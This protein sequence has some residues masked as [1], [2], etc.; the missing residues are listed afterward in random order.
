MPE[1]YNPKQYIAILRTWPQVGPAETD[2]HIVTK[3]FQADQT[4]ADVIRWAKSHGSALN[5]LLTIP[6]P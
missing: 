1:E 3:V 6:D 2:L 4:V 5:I